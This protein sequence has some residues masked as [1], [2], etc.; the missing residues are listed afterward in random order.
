MSKTRVANKRFHCK[1][2]LYLAMS[3]TSCYPRT[4]LCIRAF[5][6]QSI[7]S[8]RSRLTYQS[9]KRGTLESGLLLSTFIH[10]FL[11]TFSE[12]ELCLYDQLI[13]SSEVDDWSI[14]YWATGKDEVPP[15]FDNDV[16]R[17]LQEHARNRM[18][19]VRNVQPPLFS[20]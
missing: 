4:L 11:D 5:S 13:N 14:Y 12:R 10:R 1:Y 18:R 3:L 17:K 2:I 20:A 16:M 15:E 6:A 7:S 9:R 8:Q 19:E